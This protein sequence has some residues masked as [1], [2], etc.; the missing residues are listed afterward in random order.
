MPFQAEWMLPKCPPFELMKQSTLAWGA[1]IPGL[2]SPACQQAGWSLSK[3]TRF[4][5]AST[6]H[7]WLYMLENPFPVRRVE[8]PGADQLAPDPCAG[9]CHLPS[10]AGPLA[11]AGPDFEGSHP[12]YVPQP[13][14]GGPGPSQPPNRAKRVPTTC[15]ERSEA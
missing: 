5:G 7:T 4:F 2:I 13:Q 15:F 6:S 1:C 12:C 9:R 11:S 10:P 8:P 3:N 14:V